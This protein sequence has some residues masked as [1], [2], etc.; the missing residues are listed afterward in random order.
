MSARVTFMSPASRNAPFACSSR[1]HAPSSPRKRIFA[2]KSL[3]PFGRYMHAI[4][5][6][7]VRARTT[8]VSKSRDGTSKTGSSGKT[9]LS[10]KIATPE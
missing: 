8:R 3:P 5:A 9:L 7:G 4:V 1:T 6:L 2:A 10:S